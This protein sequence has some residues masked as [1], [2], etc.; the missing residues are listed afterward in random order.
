[1]TITHRIMPHDVF[2]RFFQMEHNLNEVSNL[3]AGLSLI[4]T[5]LRGD[6]SVNGAA[7]ASIS[8][9]AWE[10]NEG[11][12]S[13]WA[14]IHRKLVDFNKEQGLCLTGGAA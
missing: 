3:L 7:I 9:I 10:I 12:K 6:D 1:M 13:D 5:A 8:D 14:E 11:L 4:G 2:T